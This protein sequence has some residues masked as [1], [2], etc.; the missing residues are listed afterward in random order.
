[1]L[2]GLSKCCGLAE[3]YRGTGGVR[4]FDSECDCDVH[5]GG[6]GWKALHASEAGLGVSMTFDRQLPPSWVLD[7]RVP[8]HSTSCA[9]PLL[10]GPPR[11]SSQGCSTV[12]SV[13]STVVEGVYHHH[14]VPPQIYKPPLHTAP[15]PLPL[16]T[17]PSFLTTRETVN[18]NRRSKKDLGTNSTSHSIKLPLFTTTSLFKFK[19]RRD[20]VERLLQPHYPR[21]PKLPFL[22]PRQLPALLLL[23]AI[24]CSA[25]C[26]YNTRLPR[27][28]HH[29]CCTGEPAPPYE[30][31]RRITPAG[32]QLVVWTPA[33][34]RVIDLDQR[35]RR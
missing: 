10:S 9:P 35:E 6:G 23:L 1:M 32:Q 16:P 4:C 13:A 29:R 31:R 7:F 21:A 14:L 3:G 5:Q 33:W 34:Q 28:H 8:V 25:V 19:C 15:H 17:P 11:S 24:P 18:S 2:C 30:H 26:R 12:W 27:P 22:H 20:N